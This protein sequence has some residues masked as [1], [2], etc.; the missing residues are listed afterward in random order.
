MNASPAADTLAP[1]LCHDAV[2]VLRSAASGERRVA[3]DALLTGPGRTSAAPDELLVAV[4]LQPAGERA[5]SAYVRLE[6]R[7]QMEIAIV[8]AAALVALDEAG[9]VT[10]A[11]LAVTAV[12]PTVRRVPSAEQQLVGR[13][14][15]DDA[16]G[17]AARAAAADAA[18][19]SDV[20]GSASY[21]R[22]M[23][24]VIARR[25]IVAAVT[26]A[27]GGAVAVAIP[28]SDSTFGADS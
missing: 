21:R 27:R 18:P 19:I 12:A 8:G 13:P 9:T 17:A 15:G 10:A 28:A 23:V 1:L 26:R 24:E 3:L 16:I 6:Y 4:E 7:R 5:A 20:R 22:A 2:A 14:V 11:R 25:A